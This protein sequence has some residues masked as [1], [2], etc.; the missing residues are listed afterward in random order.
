MGVLTVWSTDLCV[1]HLIPPVEGPSINCVSPGNS[2]PRNGECTIIIIMLIN[3]NT[4]LLNTP[5]LFWIAGNHTLVVTSPV[6]N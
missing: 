1:L 5:T 4:C 3:S 6:T 2:V